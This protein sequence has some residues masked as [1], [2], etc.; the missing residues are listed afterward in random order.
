LR[1]VPQAAGRDSQAM[2]IDLGAS[3]Q[4]TDSAAAGQRPLF[5][6]TP[7][8][9]LESM[10]RY[11]EVGVQDFRID[12]PSP[13]IEGLRQAMAHFATEMQPQGKA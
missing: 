12:F 4:F 9:I 6:G 2:T 8:Q 11:Q 5:T 7:A 10:P 13:S 1:P 3:V